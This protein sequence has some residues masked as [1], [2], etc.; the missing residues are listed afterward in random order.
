MLLLLL[1]IPLFELIVVLLILDGVSH[2]IVILLSLVG[3]LSTEVD[4]WCE[5]NEDLECKTDVETLKN[6]R[7]NEKG[8]EN[9]EFLIAEPDD[10]CIIFDGGVTPGIVVDDNVVVANDPRLGVIGE[11]P[12]DTALFRIGVDSGVE[13]IEF[14]FDDFSGVSP[15]TSL[16]W[17]ITKGAKFSY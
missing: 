16:S 17:S 3:G 7:G 13:R 2:P 1:P 8:I 9:G 14:G 15:V 6:V 10:E 5:F 4:W 12:S 11:A